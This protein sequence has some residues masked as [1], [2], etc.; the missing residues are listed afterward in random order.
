MTT[1]KFDDDDWDDDDDRG[2]GLEDIAEDIVDDALECAGCGSMLCD[3][4]T[5]CTRC[6]N[7]AEC[8]NSLC[9]DCRGKEHF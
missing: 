6:G 1:E 3:G 9:N 7:D 4:V 5:E 8:P 2:D